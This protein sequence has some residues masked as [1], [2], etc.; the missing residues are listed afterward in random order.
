MDII[1]Y[2]FVFVKAFSEKCKIKLKGG[3]EMDFTKLLKPKMV[4]RERVE[5]VKD[6][7]STNKVF[8]V[9][10]VIIVLLFSGTFVLGAV[11]ENSQKI[12]QQEIQIENAESLEQSAEVQ[13]TLPQWEFH[14]IDL[15][16]L[17]VGGGICLIQ[18]MREKRKGREQI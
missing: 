3:D 4:H 18:I 2:F 1:S 15:W 8:T 16:I 7:A 17:G 14:S 12:P 5:F 6:F 13:K 10:A 9:I 11:S